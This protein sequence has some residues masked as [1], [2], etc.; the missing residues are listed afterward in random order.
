MNKSPMH[1]E[2]SSTT[3]ILIPTE[4]PSMRFESCGQFI[5]TPGW[6]HEQRTL[7]SF[8]LIFVRR[9][10]LPL[11]VGDRSFSI[12]RGEFILIPPETTHQGDSH[13]IDPLEFFWMHFRLPE[14][15]C[16]E[17]TGQPTPLLDGDEAFKQRPKAER[18][19]PQSP[20]PV[21]QQHNMAATC[22]PLSIPFYD[23]PSNTDRLTIMFDQLLDIYQMS[24]PS[25]SRY[26]TCFA[27]CILYEISSACQAD[28]PMDETGSKQGLQEI[29]E[30]IRMNAFESISVNQIAQRFNYSASYLSTIYKQ[31][32]GVTITAHITDI[33]LDHAKNLLLST[34]LDIQEIAENIGYNDAKYFMRVFKQHVG[35][36]PT[37]YRASFTKRHFNNH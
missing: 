30:W 3:R 8:E 13:L 26:C 18:P 25:A 28:Q 36:T 2:V 35:M 19:N 11:R 37:R 12:G 7:H 6:I 23:T 5:G 32:F 14:W 24:Y 20:E 31:H 27:T 33:R 4:E 10:T 17:F 34:S 22:E 16:G 1:N 15:R 21:Q 9:G 29:Q